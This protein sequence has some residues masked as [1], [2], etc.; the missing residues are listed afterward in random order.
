MTGGQVVILGGV[1]DNF[2]A[3]MSGGMAWAYDEPG[4]FENRINPDSIVIHR[5]ASI[6]WEAVLKG[7]IEEHVQRTGSDRARAMLSRW[8]EARG[9]FW[10]V[11]PKEMLSRLAHPLSDQAESRSYA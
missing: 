8:S 3:G 6:H 2:G 4:D 5:V 1:G 10:Q 9:K 7:I 11:C